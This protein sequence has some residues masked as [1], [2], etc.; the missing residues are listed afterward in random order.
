MAQGIDA[1][2]YKEL[3]LLSTE[4]IDALYEVVLNNSNMFTG[5]MMALRKR[6]HELHNNDIKG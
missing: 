6:W 2:M 1:K 3:C 5:K 4:T